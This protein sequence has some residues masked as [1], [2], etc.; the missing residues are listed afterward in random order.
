MTG[1]F[2]CGP[3]TKV[4]GQSLHPV[5][6]GQDVVIDV[7]SFEM[8]GRKFR[9]LRQAVQRTHN[10]GITTEIVGEQELDGRP[11]PS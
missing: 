1:G 6:I 11:G 10:C 5:P 3:T 7:S 4:L 8:V 9:N 2:T